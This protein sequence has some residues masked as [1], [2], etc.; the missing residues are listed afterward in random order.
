[1]EELLNELNLSNELKLLYK[2]SIPII[3]EYSMF[4]F[5]IDEKKTD[6]FPHPPFLIPFSYSYDADHYHMGIVK[7]W[8]TKR[9]ISYGDMTDGCSF[10]TTEIARSEKQLFSR[11]LFD[12]FVNN[13]DCIVTERLQK[14]VEL[15][16][17]KDFDFA[18]FENLNMSYAENAECKIDLLL[19]DSPLSCIAER[20]KYNGDFPSNDRIIIPS[21]IQTSCYFEIFHKE[22]IGYNAEKK[23]FSLFRKEPKYKPLEDIPEWLLPDFSKK[24]LFEKYMEKEE[25][26]KAWLTINGP[27]FTP[28]EVGDRLQRLK[29]VTNEKAYHLWVD[30][31]CEKYG[32][33]ESFIFI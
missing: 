24:E 25:F 27:G 4:K 11:L 33:H 9:T 30:F 23:G 8:F 15:M 14:C 1:M 21:K 3:D 28:S 7:H 5:Y 20:S 12:E 26:D 13:E 6:S 32:H 2:G 16:G 29:E 17:L 18:E 10:Q 22:W 31:W 19:E